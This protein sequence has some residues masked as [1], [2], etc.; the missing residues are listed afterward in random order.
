MVKA[1]T[2]TTR[3]AAE[4]PGIRPKPALPLRPLLHDDGPRRPLEAL[5]RLRGLR[6]LGLKDLGGGTQVLP[7]AAAPARLQAAAARRRHAKALH[8]Q[9][10]RLP[11]DMQVT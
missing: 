1:R 7:V 11:G 10:R 2:F 9:Q 8:R 4:H 3:G 6:P 5:Q